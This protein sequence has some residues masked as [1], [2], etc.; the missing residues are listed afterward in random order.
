MNAAQRNILVVKSRKRILLIDQE[1]IDLIRAEGNYIRIYYQFE[2]VLVRE[3]LSDIE[4]RV[5]YP[6]LLRISRSEIVNIR[7]V[8]EMIHKRSVK[9]ELLLRNNHRCTLTRSY[10]HHMADILG[11]RQYLQAEMNKAN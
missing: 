10:R 4:K 8:R 3:K 5:Q 1:T 6:P 7:S 2:S 11:S 9:M